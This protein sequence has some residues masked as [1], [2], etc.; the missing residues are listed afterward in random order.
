MQ[1]TIVENDCDRCDAKNV[2][3]K[4]FRY[5][6]GF[7]R[8]PAGGGSSAFGKE[9]DLC[10]DCVAKLLREEIKKLELEYPSDIHNFIANWGIKRSRDY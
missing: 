7:D 5:Q 10:F 9:F 1:R 8:D 3:T 6:L 4:E 2:P